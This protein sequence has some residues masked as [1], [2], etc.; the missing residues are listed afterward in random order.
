MEALLFGLSIGFVSGISPGPLMTLVLTSTLERGFRAG[1]L[2]AIAPL[3][4]D[5]PI[6][7]LCLFVLRQLPQGFLAP[8]TVAGGLFIL[9]IAVQTIRSARQER[10]P[11]EVEVTGGRD[12]LRG[13]VV[14]LFNPHPW[15][16][17]MTV[18]VPFLI[19]SWNEAAWRAA[20]FLA[21]LYSLLVGTKI[22]VAWATA[23]GRRFLSSRWYRRLLIAC[24]LLLVGLGCALIWQGL[25]AIPPTR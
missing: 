12:L 24:G 17:W 25:V 3:L 15:L 6:I 11:E 5:A 16:F 20:A 8:V 22:A 14:N 7:L 21:A 4:T 23:R 9:W 18:G 19:Q 1:L 10:A 2:T 13:T